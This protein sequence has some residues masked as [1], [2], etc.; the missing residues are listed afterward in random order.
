MLLG[1]AKLITIK[2]RKH[3]FEQLVIYIL[4]TSMDKNLAFQT[5]SARYAL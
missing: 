5:K 3:A 4:Q 1:I 2:I